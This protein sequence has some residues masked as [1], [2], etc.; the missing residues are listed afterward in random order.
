MCTT[1]HIFN[2]YN[3]KRRTVSREEEELTLATKK[4]WRRNSHEKKREV[5]HKIGTCKFISNEQYV[6]D[7]KGSD[8]VSFMRCRFAKGSEGMCVYHRGDSNG[9]VWLN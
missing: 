9:M 4:K 3:N 2:P 7:L 8:L 1:S 5:V 6:V